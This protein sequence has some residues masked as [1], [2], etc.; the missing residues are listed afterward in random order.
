[1]KKLLLC[2]ILA[3]SGCQSSTATPDPKL[4]AN[5]GVVVSEPTCQDGVCQAVIKIDEDVWHYDAIKAPVKRGDTIYHTCRYEPTREV[6]SALWTREPYVF[7]PES[8]AVQS[9]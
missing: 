4:Y 8:T 2:A 3:I 5:K 6:C 7:Y 9:W 1:M